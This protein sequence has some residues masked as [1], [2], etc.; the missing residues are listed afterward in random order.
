MASINDLSK[1]IAS[2]LATYTTEVTEGLEKAKVEVAKNTVN[3]L[4]E[5]SPKD[6]GSYSKGW[7]VKK[8]GNAL[9]VHNK[10]DYQL[11]HLLEKGHIKANG[12]RVGAKVHI[13]P[14]EEKAI[15]EFTK[16]VEKVIRE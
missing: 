9:V 15:E 1:E 16:E 2:V 5:T 6:T 14:A 7:A 4:K 13:R 12:G 10:T 8:V 11:T 3:I